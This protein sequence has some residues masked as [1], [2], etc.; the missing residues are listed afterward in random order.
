MSHYLLFYQSKAKVSCFDGKYMKNE[1][2]SL[3]VKSISLSVN[4]KWKVSISSEDKQVLTSFKIK[5]FNE[6]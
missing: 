1:K 2:N 4:F 3:N 6:T 5:S